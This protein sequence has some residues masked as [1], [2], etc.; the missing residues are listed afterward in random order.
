[1][2]VNRLWVLLPWAGL[3]TAIP[4]PSVTKNS[5]PLLYSV[6]KWQLC[7][8]TVNAYKFTFRGF[9]I[10]SD[11]HKLNF[12]SLA[13]FVYCIVLPVAKNSRII[14]WSPALCHFGVWIVQQAGIKY[15]SEMCS[16]EC[17]GSSF[18]LTTISCHFLLALTQSTQPTAHTWGATAVQ[19]TNDSS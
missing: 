14:L 6:T 1:M 7:Q 18:Y 10:K 4:Y 15:F 19:M 8:L 2:K 5:V 11:L 12:I 13:G 3:S 16:A 17:T 9:Y